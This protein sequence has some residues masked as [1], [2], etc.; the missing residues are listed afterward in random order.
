MNQERTNELL[1]SLHTEISAT[2]VRI[3]H[4]QKVLEQVTSDMN[5]DLA[6]LRV[7]V[8]RLEATFVETW[9][10]ERPDCAIIADALN[11]EV[12]R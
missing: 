8:L 3:K 6:A 1:C 5:Q 11:G 2:E 12:R 9:P 10:K 7:A 4:W